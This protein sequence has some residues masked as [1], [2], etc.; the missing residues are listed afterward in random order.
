[1]RLST[2]SEGTGELATKIRD[3]QSPEKIIEKKHS[4]TEP[5][6]RTFLALLDDTGFWILP[7]LQRENVLDATV[8]TLEGIQNGR[9]HAVSKTRTASD[10]LHG[11][12]QGL[13]RVCW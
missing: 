5:E 11:C 13:G 10:P 1:M 4:V 8:W 3:Y 9:Y 12:L 6:E 7:S 2:T